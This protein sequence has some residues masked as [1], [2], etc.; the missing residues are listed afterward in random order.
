MNNTSFRLLYNLKAFIEDSTQTSVPSTSNTSTSNNSESAKEALMN[1]VKSPVFYIVIGAIVLLIIAFYL[2]RRIVKAKPNSVVIITRKG[3]VFKTLDENHPKFFM[4]PF[5]D[6]LG[7]TISLKETEFSSDKLFINNGPDFLYQINFT[8]T[9]KVTDAEK[10][11]PFNEKHEEL[12]LKKI[13]ENLREF[14]DK[15]NA[16]VLVKDYR[17]HN[18][19]ILRLVNDSI[20]D[21]FVEAVSFKINLIQ[22][23][24]GR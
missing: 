7:A 14:A 8:L 24:G 4:V 12:I 15:G 19:D 16:L 2:Y 23:L 10:F 17:E 21:L 1:I 18:E 20:K 9:Y 13:N 6:K 3:K 22:P 5:V 11:Y